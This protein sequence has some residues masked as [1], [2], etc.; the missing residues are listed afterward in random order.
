MHN[1]HQCTVISLP[2]QPQ[3]PSLIWINRLGNK[4]CF[5]LEGKAVFSSDKLFHQI[6]YIGRLMRKQNMFVS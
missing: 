3:I 6:T 5:Q 1:I 4:C 2:W